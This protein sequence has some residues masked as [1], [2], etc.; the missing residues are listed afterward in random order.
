M[1]KV[2]LLLLIAISTHALQAQ[3]TA[4]VPSTSD[5]YAVGLATIFE[6]HVLNALGPV[7]EVLTIYSALAEASKAIGIANCQRY[8]TEAAIGRCQKDVI[9]SAKANPL[10]HLSARDRRTL[11]SITGNLN[12]LAGLLESNDP[13]V[14]KEDARIAVEQVERR[15]RR[16]LANYSHVELGVLA[17][18]A[19]FTDP[20]AGTYDCEGWLSVSLGDAPG[21]LYGTYAGTYSIKG[22]SELGTIQI[23]FRGRGKWSDPNVGRSGWT[24]LNR[25]RTTTDGF[26]FSWG[27]T[28]RGSR[29]GAELPNSGGTTQCVLQQ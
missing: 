28:K 10:E 18:H 8:T 9:G 20:V 22:K 26:Q 5:Y 24:E 23:E 17:E 16:L 21:G 11:G 14:D 2:L 13:N 19:T 12:Y 1:K 25:E 7:G 6:T 4:Q 3:Q 15:L 29:D 27:V